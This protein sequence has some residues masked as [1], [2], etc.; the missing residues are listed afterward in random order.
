ML[1][2]LKIWKILQREYLKA[3]R[4]VNRVE[5]KTFLSENS[6]SLCESYL[7]FVKRLERFFWHATIITRRQRSIIK[8]T[9]CCSLKA[10]PS[11]RVTAANHARQTLTKHCAGTSCSSH[12]GD[13]YQRFLRSREHEFRNSHRALET[14]ERTRNL[15][16]RKREQRRRMARSVSTT[17]TMCIEITNAFR[18]S[19]NAEW[20]I[21]VRRVIPSKLFCLLNEIKIE[22]RRKKG[23]KW[24]GEGR[25]ETNGRDRNKMTSVSF[26]RLDLY[27]SV[28]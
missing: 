21:S 5:P 11:Y 17:E 12:G 4:K 19:A 8:I 7:G 24:R 3:A 27:L 10:A 15:R 9:V 14:K 20:I 18:V 25:K 13:T 2:I 26:R 1:K 28:V 16:P 6:Q 22:R 23:T